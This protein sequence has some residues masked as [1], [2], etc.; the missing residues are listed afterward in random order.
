MYLLQQGW[1]WESSSFNGWAKV[2]HMTTQLEHEGW[3]W[4]EQQILMNKGLTTETSV[5]I[6][7]GGLCISVC[8]HEGGAGGGVTM[9]T[10]SVSAPGFPLDWPPTVAVLKPPQT[11]QPPVSLS[12]H[13]PRARL[14]FRTK[15]HY[16]VI[17]IFHL[18]LSLQWKIKYEILM[19]NCFRFGEYAGTK[20]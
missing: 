2:Y 1:C 9:E 14:T 6:K 8:S 10:I 15:W 16:L 20:Q 3:N 17:T 5:G 11:P 7:R 19:K 4:F 13:H 18:F 12:F